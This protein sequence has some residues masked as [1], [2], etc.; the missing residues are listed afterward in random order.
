MADYVLIM[1]AILVGGQHFIP[2]RA[3]KVASHPG[4]Q[5]APFTSFPSE[6]V[7]AFSGEETWP[8]WFGRV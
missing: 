3:H 4:G 7:A 6:I 2:T 1:S 5:R 8:T